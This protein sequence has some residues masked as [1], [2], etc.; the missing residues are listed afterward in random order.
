M[1]SLRDDSEYLTAAEIAALTGWSIGYVRNLA[2]KDQWRR[3]R[4]LTDGRATLYHWQDVAD[5]RARTGH[6]DSPR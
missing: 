6:Q 2:T 5:T 1:I 4:S 3:R